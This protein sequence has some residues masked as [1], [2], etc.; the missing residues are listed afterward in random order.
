MINAV[1]A[2]SQSFNGGQPSEKSQKGGV[3]PTR[4]HR[5]RP[6][7]CHMERHS[8]PSDSLA[9]FPHSP[10]RRC[11]WGHLARYWPRNIWLQFC[12]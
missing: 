4:T 3:T 10:R 1:S 2:V 8:T 9:P 7:A 12:W 11:I 6:H 5:V